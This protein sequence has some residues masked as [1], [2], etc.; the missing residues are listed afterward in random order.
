MME[1]QQKHAMPNQND[2]LVDVVARPETS[3]KY[4]LYKNMGLA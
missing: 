1:D 3:L 4:I 2:Q